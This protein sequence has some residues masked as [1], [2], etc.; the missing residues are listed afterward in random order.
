MSDHILSEE[1]IIKHKYIRRLMNDL[2]KRMVNHKVINDTAVVELTAR[3]LQELLD[4]L[5]SLVLK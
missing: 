5:D 3:E 2:Y 4:F 1:K